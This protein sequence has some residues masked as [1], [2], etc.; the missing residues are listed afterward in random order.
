M[1]SKILQK[2]GSNNPFAAVGLQLTGSVEDL[3]NYR[4]VHERLKSPA[5]GL[6]ENSMTALASLG[7]SFIICYK[8]HIFILWHVL[9]F[10]VSILLTIKF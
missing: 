8:A 3:E 9:L 4:L 1:F 6:T 2:I 7:F 10:Y 5:T